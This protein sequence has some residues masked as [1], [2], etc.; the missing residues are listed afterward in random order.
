[1]SPYGRYKSA[2]RL[3]ELRVIAQARMHA[4]QKRLQYIKVV[5]QK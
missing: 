2:M 4:D 3:V 5:K 1:M